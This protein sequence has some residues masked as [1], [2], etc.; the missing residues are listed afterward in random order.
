[1]IRSSVRRN[2]EK[3]YINVNV[4]LSLCLTEQYSMKAYGG[5]AVFIHVFLTSA[6]VGSE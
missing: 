5:V 2:E 3:S 1:V 4:K 6:L